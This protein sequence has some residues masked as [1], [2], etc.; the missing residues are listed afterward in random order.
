VLPEL[1]RIAAEVRTTCGGADGRG[2]LA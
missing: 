2:T 1:R